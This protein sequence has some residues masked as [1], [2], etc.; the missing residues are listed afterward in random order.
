MVSV[1]RVARS[2]SVA[3]RLVRRLS[4]CWV[5]LAAPSVT[6]TVSWRSR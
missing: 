2:A 3:A 5:A 1:A 6:V 4:I